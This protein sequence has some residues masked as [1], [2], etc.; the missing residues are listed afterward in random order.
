MASVLG[1]KKVDDKSNEITA[2]PEL[3]KVLSLKGCIVTIDAIGCQKKI[4]K[5]IID[6][7]GDYVIALKKNQG[8]LYERVEKLFEQALL[9]DF[10]GLIKSEYRQCEDDRGRSE[11]RYCQ[12]LTNINQEIDPK[13]EWKGLNSIAYVDYLRTE[14][15]KTTRERR[16]FISS[17]TAQSHKL[18]AKAIRKHWCIENQLHW[19]LDV[20]FNEDASRIRKDNAPENLAIIRHIALNLLKQEKTLKFGVKNKRKNAGWDDKYLLKVLTS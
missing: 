19:V 20:S 4:I 8:G 18:I 6:Q 13:G 3:I 9:N 12:I 10:K 5:Q 15:G 1:Q 17:L 14:K 2:I 11:T 16:Y 7:D